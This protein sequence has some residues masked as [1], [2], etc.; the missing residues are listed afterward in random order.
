MSPR[1]QSAIVS[2]PAS[3]ACAM[4][5][6][7]ADQP[8][9]PSCSKRASCGLT[10]THAGPAASIRA[11]QC[12]STAS[13]ARSAGEPLPA[14]VSR[15]T[16]QADRDRDRARSAFPARPRERRAPRQNQSRSG[17]L[18]HDEERAPLGRG[19]AE[20]Q[21]RPRSRRIRLRDA[22]NPLQLDRDSARGLGHG[23]VAAAVRLHGLC[24]L[25]RGSGGVGRDQPSVEEAGRQTACYLSRLAVSHP[26]NARTAWPRW[27]ISSLRSSESSAIVLSPGSSSGRKAGS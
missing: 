16:G 2:K 4:T 1:L 13:A 8:G 14:P 24:R 22:A 27:L 21:V 12:P 20:M 18:S 6:F 7:S 10:A 15:A 19:Q 5:A 3:R 11:R 9:A 25:E 17:L 26:C 23:G